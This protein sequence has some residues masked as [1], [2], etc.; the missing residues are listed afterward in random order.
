MGCTGCLLAATRNPAPT[1]SAMAISRSPIP[2][3]RASRQMINLMAAVYG[4]AQRGG[5]REGTGT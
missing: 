3:L 1:P 2:C 4:L 5:R